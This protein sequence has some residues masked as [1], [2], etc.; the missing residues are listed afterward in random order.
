[1]ATF[2]AILSVYQGD[3]VPFKMFLAEHAHADI[4]RRAAAGE[5]SKDPSA[6]SRPTMPAPLACLLEL[7][8]DAPPVPLYR[9]EIGEIRGITVRDER[10]EPKRCHHMPIAGGGICKEKVDLAASDATNNLLE[11]ESDFFYERGSR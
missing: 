10:I 1:M 9:L 7:R 5:Q 4:I 3:Y 11:A 2:S 8:T 6:T